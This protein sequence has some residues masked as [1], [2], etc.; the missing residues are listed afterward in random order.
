MFNKGIPPRGENPNSLRDK[1]AQI[2]SALAE[3]VPEINNAQYFHVDPALFVNPVDGKISHTDMHDYLH[4]TPTGYRK[5]MEPLVEEIENLLKNF[6][7][8]DAASACS[9]GSAGD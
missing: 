8:A 4:F 7:T 3:K 9:H 1:I 6:M 5:L 2:N